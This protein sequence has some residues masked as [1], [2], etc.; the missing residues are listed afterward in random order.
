M[1]GA[2]ASGEWT[3]NVQRGRGEIATEGA[4]TTSGKGEMR[5][6][7]ERTSVGGVSDFLGGEINL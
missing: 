4:A 1:I 3:K 5:V 2:S 7:R 6:L